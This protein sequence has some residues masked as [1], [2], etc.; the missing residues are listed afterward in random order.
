[1]T[2]PYKPEIIP[3]PGIGEELQKALAPL[4][5]AFLKR[6]RLE[7]DKQE[8]K[9][10]QQ[11]FKLRQDSAM[12]ERAQL[13]QTGEALRQMMI[14]A[15]AQQVPLGDVL[16]GVLQGMP[17]AASLA[18]PDAMTQGLGP[19]AQA[20]QG[21]P[22]AAIPQAIQLS[23]DLRK[24]IFEQQTERKADTA[25]TNAV[26]SVPEGPKREI[27]RSFLNLKKMGLDLPVETQRAFWPELFPPDMD[28]AVMSVALKYGVAGG[29]AWG[30]IRSLF[31]LPKNPLV[32][33]DFRFPITLNS[34]QTE[35]QM[36]A[37]MH[38]KS[39]SL[40]GPLIDKLVDQTGGISV[41][42]Q[43]KRAFDAT[44][45]SSGGITGFFS[46]MGA[47][48]LNGLIPPEQ[49]QL[50]QAQFAW[51][52]SYRYLV[53][54]QQTSDREFNV[55]LNTVSES[56]FDSPEVKAQKR[57]FRHVMTEAAHDLSTGN[58]LPTQAAG[59]VLQQA[60][61]MGL[62]PRLLQVLQQHMTDAA[63]FEASGAPALFTRDPND[64]Q[65]EEARRLIL[66]MIMRDTKP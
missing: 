25:I 33:D 34:K 45:A 8:L 24:R 15:D 47:M 27:A 7:L 32:S 30:Q 46:N 61:A 55:I 59:K 17:G 2:T 5:D 14:V 18:P 64:A 62:D 60:Q 48:V 38:Y 20:F 29:L 4:T 11:E 19:L 35:K 49:Q 54:G 9:Q 63:K 1:M 23:P 16:G 53:S 65:T 6:Q 66:E 36:T 39:M 28:P 40:N 43:V 58:L 57:A 51:T 41:P 52:N 12:H 13:E 26:M 50:I 56:S 44:Q 3:V 37:A 42:A 21:I 31:H 10:R 22:A